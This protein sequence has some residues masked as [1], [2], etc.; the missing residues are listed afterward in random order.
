MYI[1]T[2]LSPVAGEPFALESAQFG[3]VWVVIS[4]PQEL[5]TFV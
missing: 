1:L 3:F 2:S 5:S 4:K